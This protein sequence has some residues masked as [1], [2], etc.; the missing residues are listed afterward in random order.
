MRGCVMERVGSSGP[1]S[2]VCL[3]CHPWFREVPFSLHRQRSRPLR[4]CLLRSA[5]SAPLLP[6]RPLF[7]WFLGRGVWRAGEAAAAAGDASELRESPKR[8]GPADTGSPA[9]PGGPG[10][11]RPVS[12]R[13]VASVVVAARRYHAEPRVAKLVG[14]SRVTRGSSPGARSCLQL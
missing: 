5:R 7:C 1:C 11:G 12:E 9:S 8:L 2:G 3:G 6:D 4:S 10:G 14:C 13:Q